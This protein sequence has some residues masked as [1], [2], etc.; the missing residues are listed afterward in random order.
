M[1]EI[2]KIVTL[3]NETKASSRRGGL[4]GIYVASNSYFFMYSL[5][6]CFEFLNAHAN[7]TM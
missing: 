5:L 2:N 4:E 3:A 1:T 7:V 6:M